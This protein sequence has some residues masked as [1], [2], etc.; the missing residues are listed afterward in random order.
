MPTINYEE[1]L[2]ELERLFAIAEDRFR[3][4]PA[5]QEPERA[6][7]ALRTLFATPVQSYREALLGC[8]IARILDDTI[9][10]RLPYANQGAAAYNG[11]TLD[12]RVINPF[13]H[14]LEIPAS[15]GP[16]LAAFRRNVS[17]TR[18][19]RRGLRDIAAYD[20]MLEY[21]ELLQAAD[22]EMQRELTILLLQFFIALRENSNVTLARIE[23]LS[24]DQ[25]HRLIEA[26]LDTPSRGLL[27]VLLAVALLQT[28]NECY[29]LGWEIEWQRI[30]VA[31]QAR[32][33]GGDITIRKNGAIHFA[34]EVTE[35]PVERARVISTFNSK[36]SRYAIRDYLF[37]ITREPAEDA[38]EASQQYF[39]QGHEV[40]FLHIK[41]WIVH[42][43]GTIG[44][45]GRQLFTH[46]FLSLLDEKS[47]PA[48]LK[49]RWN[50]L[51]RE[52][53]S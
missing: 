4:N 50:A 42:I 2:A 16:F 19:T 8:C 37:L 32:D 41:V 10:I 9:D 39:G 3:R 14:R 12:E 51:I 28:I 35:R 29:D 45:D 27:P 36:I 11:R 53:F 6:V 22:K 48:T 52:I 5:P 34:I 33:A 38:K 21:I 30:N 43:L 23:R 31:D 46:K 15:K 26:L 17:F 20:A 24:L 7:A 1:A 25:Q 18:E 47:V 13:L 44:S 40:N 49:V